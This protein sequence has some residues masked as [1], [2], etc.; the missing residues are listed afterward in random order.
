MVLLIFCFHNLNSGVVIMMAMTLFLVIP[1]TTYTA[2]Q[3]QP[4]MRSYKKGNVTIGGLFPVHVRGGFRSKFMSLAEA[5]VFAIGQINND[6]K[7]LP[8]ITL[9]YDITDTNLMNRRA[10]KTTLDYVNVHKFAFENP[11]LNESCLILPRG[12]FSPVVAVVGT[13]NSRSSILVSNLLE[14]EDIPLISYAATSDELSSS[15]YPSFFRTVPPDRFQSKVMSD[16]AREFNWTYV[17]AIAQDDAYGRSGIEYF[18]KHTKPLGLC[19]A[20]ENYFPANNQREEKIKTIIEELK[21]ME[22]VGVIILY[23]TSEPAL[24]VLREAMRQGLEGRTWIA[25]EAW[26]DHERV[27]KEKE[28]QPI[29]KGMLGVVF[30]DITVPSYKRYLLSRTSAYRPEPWWRHFWEREFKCTFNVTPSDGTKRCSNHLKVSESVFKNSLSDSKATYVINAVYAIAHALDAIFKCKSPPMSRCPQTEPFIEPKDVLDYLKKVNF[31]TEVSKVFFDDN[32]DSLASYSIINYRAGNDTGGRVET[33]G[34]WEVGELKLNTSHIIWNNGLSGNHIPRSVCSERCG[35][36]Y[37]QTQELNCC[38][39]CIRCSQDTVTSVSGA[40]NCTPCSEDH[41]SNEARTECIPVPIERIHWGDPIGI[42][43]AFIACLGT[44]A[45]VLVGAVFVWRNETPIV[46]ASNREL[47]YTFLFCIGMNYLWAL[48]NLAEPSDFICPLS[49][50]WFYIFYTVAIVVLGVKTKR[51]VHLFEHRVPRSELT[52]TFIEKHKHI[53]VIVGVTALDVLI[54]V[55]W[56][57]VDVPKPNVDKSLRTTYFLECLENSNLVGSFCRYLLIAILVIMSFVCCYFAFKSRK[58]PHNFN[59]GKFIA[60]ALYVIVVSWVTFYPVYLNIRGKYSVVIAGAASII[61]ATGLLVC[62]FVPKIYIILFH[63]EKNTVAY[64]K[65][66]ISN[67]TFRRSTMEGDSR[68]RSYNT[69]DS[70]AG[71]T[72]TGTP[73]QAGTPVQTGTPTSSRPASQCMKETE[74]KSGKVITYL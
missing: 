45:S 35:P 41:I 7:L 29:L 71:G 17:A 12:P 65:S 74:K 63:P 34:T 62:I 39:Q 69:P 38:W 70:N 61:A 25:S 72:P 73:V 21:D 47:S 57:A 59:E 58:L 20:Y 18:R 3:I 68:H 56:F 10:M 32:G 11:E 8:N 22:E 33:V 5:M 49:Q 46:K 27:I 64:M 48:V 30:T 24:S 31:T 42:L 51:I 54:L 19:I 14:V 13:G 4:G 43:V 44:L 6:T 53:L 26:G 67:H 50:A 40:M 52:K 55:I 15:A 66:Q 9:G 60:F 16:I 2:A 37:R 28:L 36:G 23:C 1:Q